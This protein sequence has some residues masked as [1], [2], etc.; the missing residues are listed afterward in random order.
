M[1]AWVEYLGTT[2]DRPTGI[3]RVRLE[4]HLD[5]KLPDDYWELAIERQGLVLRDAFLDLPDEGEVAFGILLLV[6]NP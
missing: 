3:D 2:I 5:A 1:S 6:L 4:R